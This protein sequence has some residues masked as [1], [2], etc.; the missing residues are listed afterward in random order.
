MIIIN[1]IFAILLILLHA[2]AL[3]CAYKQGVISGDRKNK[4][5]SKALKFALCEI[6]KQCHVKGDYNS[7]GRVC[8]MSI[9]EALADAEGG[10]K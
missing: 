7:C 8:Y 4:R 9:R 2:A 6:C 10:S 5:L 1:V 3:W